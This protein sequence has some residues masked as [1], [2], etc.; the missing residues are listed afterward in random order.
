MDALRTPKTVNY[1]WHCT[2]NKKIAIEN[3]KLL[4]TRAELKNKTTTNFVIVEAIQMLFLQVFVIEQE[5]F[6]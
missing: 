4:R 3:G 2:L 5:P 6:Q 1:R